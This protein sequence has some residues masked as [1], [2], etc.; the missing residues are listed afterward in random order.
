M[1]LDSEPDQDISQSTLYLS[2]FKS[3]KPETLSKKKK[4]NPFTPRNKEMEDTLTKRLNKV[5]RSLIPSR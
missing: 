2:N 3:L 4:T 5:A 1:R